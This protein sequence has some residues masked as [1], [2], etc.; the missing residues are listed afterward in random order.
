MEE[1]VVEKPKLERYRIVYEPS[2]VADK[3]ITWENQLN[4]LADAGY[5]IKHPESKF[6]IMELEEPS[7]Y[8]NVDAIKPVSHEEAE[9]WLVNG[10]GWRVDS[11]Y[12]KYTILVRR[13][14]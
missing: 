3:R 8:E 2:I 7:K 1:Q 4:A 6:I 10:E 13:R 12:S 9:H 11:I 14:K 5:K